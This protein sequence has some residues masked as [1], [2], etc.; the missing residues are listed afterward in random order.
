MY[1]RPKSA[2]RPTKLDFLQMQQKGKQPA[3]IPSIVAEGLQQKSKPEKSFPDEKGEFLL[4][5][6]EI[7]ELERIKWAM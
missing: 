2:K 7:D 5:E 4:D 6:D 1:L 3:K